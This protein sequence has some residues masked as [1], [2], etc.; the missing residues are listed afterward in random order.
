[1]TDA[2]IDLALL[3]DPHGEEEMLERRLALVGAVEPHVIGSTD[4]VLLNEAPPLL[5]YEVIRCQ[6]CLFQRSALER[7][8]FEA[9]VYQQYF[10]IQPMLDFH[11]QAVMRRI[12]EVGLGRGRRRP[13]GTL[14][15]ARRLYEQ[16]AGA[17]RL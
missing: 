17:K 7:V 14:K 13:A 8:A 9:R 1:M 12:K 3:L 15:A 16:V 10:D 6:D 2:D 5:A 4:I 11:A